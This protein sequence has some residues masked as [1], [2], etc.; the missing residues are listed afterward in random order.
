ML[1]AAVSPHFG[2][3]TEAALADTP[4]VFEDGV[5]IAAASFAP[6][7]LLIAA[8]FAL[9]ARPRQSVETS[10]SRLALAL[11]PAALAL[12]VLLPAPQ[13]EPTQML[14]LRGPGL[15]PRVSIG[16][17]YPMPWIPESRQLL[18]GLGFALLAA[19]VITLAR[20]R[21]HPAAALAT[22]M[23]LATV[24]YPLAWA[25]LNN[26]DFAP[27]WA[28]QSPATTLLPAAPLL[29]LALTLMRRAGRDATAWRRA[30]PR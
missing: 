20:A 9:P 19:V 11:V 13:P 15:A 25:A 6:T 27:Y 4:S 22:G 14:E 28:Y 5:D 1:A 7:A 17:P 3:G 24:A 26:V 30:W 29:L 12:V 23:V 16:P 2:M 18:A 10:L 21:R 8:A